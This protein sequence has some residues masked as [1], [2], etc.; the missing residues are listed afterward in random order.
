MCESGGGRSRTCDLG[1]LSTPPSTIL[2][3]PLIALAGTR[4]GP[5]IRGGRRQPPSPGRFRRHVRARERP[6]SR[7]AARKAAKRDAENPRG[8]AVWKTGGGPHDRSS[9]GQRP[10]GRVGRALKFNRVARST[11][12]AS[13]KMKGQTDETGRGEDEARPSAAYTRL[14]WSAPARRSQPVPRQSL[15]PPARAIRSCG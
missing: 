8:R 12:P 4:S 14:N 3:M 10:A 5:G 9:A 2:I 6:E 13:Q 15:R 11:R 7:V 1:I